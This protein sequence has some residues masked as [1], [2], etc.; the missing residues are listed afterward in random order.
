MIP[1]EVVQEI[2]KMAKMTR[3]EICGLISSDLK[4]YPI[5]NVS[6]YPDRCFVFSKPDYAKAMSQI[7]PGQILCIYHSHP[8][9]SPEPSQ[10]DLD[11][12]RRSKCNALIVSYNDYRWIYAP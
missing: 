4:I 11:F 9:A 6:R 2:Q 12:I 8:Q 3:E 10:E 5:R 7:P 1:A